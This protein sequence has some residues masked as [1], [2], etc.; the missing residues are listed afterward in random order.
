MD[1]G[2]GPLREIPLWE[3]LFYADNHDH[4]IESRTNTVRDG[5]LKA[6]KNIDFG[7]E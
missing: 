1:R 2:R 7:G 3:V 5:V 6:V 4:V